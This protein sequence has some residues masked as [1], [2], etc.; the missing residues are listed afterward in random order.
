[1]AEE[2]K[3]LIDDKGT[4]SRVDP[5]G[6]RHRLRAIPDQCL[7]AW[8][9]SQKLSLPGA[10]S[11]GSKVVVGGMGGSA[12]AGDLAADL[13][14]SKLSSASTLAPRVPILVVRDLAFPFSLDQGTIFIASSYSGN[15]EETIALFDQAVKAKARTIAIGS[16]GKLSQRARNA[17]VPLLHIDVSSEPRTAVAY[18][19]MLILGVLSGL[20][21]LDLDEDEA[22]SAISSVSHNAS[23]WSEDVPAVDNPAK[24]I[25]L[26]L[27]DNLIIVYGSGLFSGMARRWKSQFNENAK[28]W[29]FYEVL[30]ELLHNSVEAFA[31][32]IGQPAMALILDP[33][34]KDDVTSGAVVRKPG[35]DSTIHERHNRVILETLANHDIPRMV[36]NGD[37]S[38]PLARILNMLLLGDYVSYYLALLRGVDPSPNPSINAAK[39]LLLGSG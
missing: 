4:Y 16:G 6:L 12:M 18:N 37:G 10:W 1:M 35:V 39:E 30:P 29:S 31:S 25:A 22:T 23:V 33:L 2:A 24:R 13:A 34:T 26:E 38:S 20:R 19:L 21:L 17:G 7:A 28:M 14:A 5:S 3:H 32:P 9:S 11:S 15:T 36:L 8:Q 27:M